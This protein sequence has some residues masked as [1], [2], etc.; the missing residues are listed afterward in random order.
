[1]KVV[2]FTDDGVPRSKAERQRNRR[3]TGS[4][5]VPPPPPADQP[6]GEV[7]L[8]IIEETEGLS[9]AEERPALVAI[10]RNL[11]RHLDDP[12]YAGMHNQC[13]RALE[14]AMKPLRRTKPKVRRLATVKGMTR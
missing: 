12:Q 1:M 2:T 10:A 8:A 13:F 11:A 9:M 14:L 3:A 6:P 4:S 5:K 7:E